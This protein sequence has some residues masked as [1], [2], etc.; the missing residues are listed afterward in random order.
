MDRKRRNVKL[1]DRFRAISEEIA[2]F[3]MN[4]VLDPKGKYNGAESR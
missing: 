3:L 4:Y 2:G 1:K